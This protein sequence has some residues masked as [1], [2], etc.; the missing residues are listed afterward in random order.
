MIDAANSCMKDKAK[1]VSFTSC[2]E[3][4]YFNVEFKMKGFTVDNYYFIGLFGHGL[5]HNMLRSNEE[6]DIITS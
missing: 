1:L 2:D 6:N 3:L 4:E 5:K